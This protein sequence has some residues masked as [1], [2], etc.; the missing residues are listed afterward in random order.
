MQTG[1][2]KD[3]IRGATFIVES[4]TLHCT[5]CGEKLTYQCQSCANPVDNT[6]FC[7]GCGTQQFDVPECE[8]CGSYLKKN[9]MGENTKLD[10]CEKCRNK[11]AQQN[12]ST[13]V[14]TPAPQQPKPN[15]DDFE[16]DIPF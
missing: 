7:G 1:Q 2:N 9:D 3:I 5:S 4:T 11:K 8:Q 12:L 14:S 15:F 13:L 16:D 6:R 10:G